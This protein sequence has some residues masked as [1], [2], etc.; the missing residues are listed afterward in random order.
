ML[1]GW[2]AAL[3]AILLSRRT[4]VSTML[5]SCRVT[6][7]VVLSG[8]GLTMSV[9]LSGQRVPVP[10][11]T[12]LPHRRTAGTAPRPPA[13]ATTGVA[14]P[15]DGTARRMSASFKAIVRMAISRSETSLRSTWSS[16]ECVRAPLPSSVLAMTACR[17]QLETTATTGSSV[18]GRGPQ[19]ML[20]P[21]KHHITCTLRVT[22]SARMAGKGPGTSR[23]PTQQP[24]TL[25]PLPSAFAVAT[26]GW[27]LLLT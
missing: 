1:S 23:S 22:A 6:A 12:T 2:R 9:M 15:T 14:T 5:S 25:S 7:P 16:G 17:G 26:R 27:N 8:W 18:I 20:R 19:T 11:P 24:D 4:T 3:S 10:V 21:I 13:F